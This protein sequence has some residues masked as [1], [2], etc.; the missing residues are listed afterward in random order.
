MTDEEVNSGNME[1]IDGE[2][3]GRGILLKVY[4]PQKKL[5]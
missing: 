3:H 5:I 1:Q 2:Q 4:V